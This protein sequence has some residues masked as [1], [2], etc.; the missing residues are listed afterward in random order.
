MR[1]LIAGILALGMLAG[2]IL[3]NA[4]CG[5]SEAPKLPKVPRVGFLSASASPPFIEGLREGLRQLG[6]VEG[7]TIMIEWRLTDKAEELPAI[8]AELVGLGVELII[9][10]GTSAIEAAK[11]KTSS[12]PI[13]M[14]NSGDAVGTGLVASLARPG[15]NVTGLTQISAKL[16][17]KRLELLKEAIPDLSRVAV[18]SNPNHPTTPLKYAE[19]EA[20][21]PQLGLQLQSLQVREANDLEGAFAAATRERA[22]ALITLRDPFT[23]KH[24][25][26]IAELA[27]KSR[28]PTM[29][30]T[31]NYV[32]AGGLMLYGPSIKDL[33]Q[34]TAIYVDK[35]LKGANPAELPVEQP[36]TFELVI[37]LKAAE[38]IG[39][40]LPQS[41]L[42]RANEVIR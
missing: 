29:Y 32:D 6:Y 1:R 22:G 18:L 39:F 24:E 36:T 8:A 33:Y 10:G 16:S 9:A 27:T 20:A 7:K 15:G 30:E 12:I 11:D 35:I 2:L 14:T 21:A 41:V 23:I 34:R 4:G 17:A 37:N 40:T 3:V 38:A 13:V 19:I 42:V 5:S 26:R 25:K 28:L 31:R